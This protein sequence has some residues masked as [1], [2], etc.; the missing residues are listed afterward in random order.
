MSRLHI[1][2]SYP[3][4]FTLYVSAEYLHITN[5]YVPAGVGAPLLDTHTTSEHADADEVCQSC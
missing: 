1:P 4:N 3:I 2:S 5:I